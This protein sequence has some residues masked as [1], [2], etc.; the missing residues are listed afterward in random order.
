[1]IK[2][3]PLHRAARPMA[4]G[5]FSMALLTAAL[6]C[7]KMLFNNSSSSA[8]PPSSSSAITRESHGSF[9]PIGSGS[10][11]VNHTC[12]DCHGGFDSFKQFTCQS[13][14]A[15]ATDVAAGRHTFIT[16][17]QNDSAGC[18][19]CHPNGRETAI[20]N[21]DHSAK[22]FAI[23]KGPHSNL[24][25]SDCHAWT[26][27]SRPFSCVGCHDHA[28]DVTDKAH[29]SIT[30]YRYDSYGCYG[31]HPNGAE[32]AIATSDHSTRFFPILTGSHTQLACSSCHTDPSTSKTFVCTTCHLQAKSATQ[33][34]T[35][36]G[37]VWSDASCYNCHPK[38]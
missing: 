6:G 30:G 27:T 9:F 22:Y 1:M 38:D 33:H 37:Y 18:Y 25:C 8:A 10:Y 15:H 14:H 20:S 11:H 26:T 4:H 24:Q 29:V 21:A 23:S 12:D 3:A 35:V 19:R 17:F 2:D 32:T 13:C 7:D 5:A 16:D 34:A 36:A 31:C 28:Q